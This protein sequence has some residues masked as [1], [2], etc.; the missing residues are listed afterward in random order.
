[1]LR[2][3][4]VDNLYTASAVNSEENLNLD[5]E[6]NAKSPQNFEPA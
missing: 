1:M 6:E 3:F 4:L 5:F 2:D